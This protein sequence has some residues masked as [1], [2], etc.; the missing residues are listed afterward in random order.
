MSMIRVSVEGVG[1][2]PNQGPVVVLK[3]V[4]GERVLPIWIGPNEATAIQMKLE[5]QEYI[6]PLTHDLIGI[7]LSEVGVILERIEITALKDTT[8]YAELILRTNGD[9]LRVDARP[10]DSVAIALRCDAE[11]LADDSLFRSPTSMVQTEMPEGGVEQDAEQE[12][13]SER[14]RDSLKRRLREIDPGE[15]GFFRLGG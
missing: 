14:E 11:I 8:Y 15:F 12:D 3:E 13:P 6:R 2:D 9:T 1:L 5:G 4:D 10:S 7:L